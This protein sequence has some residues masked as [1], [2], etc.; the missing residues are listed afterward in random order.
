MKR[1]KSTFLLML[2]F[3][4]SSIFAQQSN[5]SNDRTSKETW[6][7]HETALKKYPD[8]RANDNGSNLQNSWY[9]DRA[10]K[11]WTAGLKGGVTAF[12]GDADKMVP[13]WIAGPFVKYSISQTF[14]LRAEYN[15]GVLNGE[16]KDQGPS[17]FKDQFNF[18]SNFQDWSIQAHFTLGNISFLRPLRKTQLYFFGG[19][20]QGAY[21]S[22]A[23]FTDMRLFTGDYYLTSYFGQGTPNPNFGLEVEETYEGRHAILPFGIGAKH[24]LS[25]SFD[26]GLE[27]RMTMVRSDEIDV[28]STAIWQNRNP[29]MY[30]VLA[31]SIGYKFGNKN[32]QHYDWLSPIESV[33]EK[34]EK[35]DSLMKDSDNDGVSDY[36]DKEP[37]T[38][39]D[40]EVYGSGKAVDSDGDGIPDCRD[41]EPFSPRGAEVDEDGVAIDSDG[42]GV[43]DI[44]DREPNSPPGALVDRNGV[45]II[46][47]CACEDVVFPSVYFSSNADGTI[48]P[49]YYSVL[50]QIAERM[51]A[52]P[53]KKLIISGFGDQ[54]SSKYNTT[55]NTRR[56]DAM[57]K[58]L[59]EKYGISRDRMIADYKGTMNKSTDTEHRG[60]RIDFR[61]E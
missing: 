13:G 56:I 34:V 32:S 14:G 23:T 54:R 30:S 19:I 9:Q 1:I 28:Y 61:F 18:T 17:M 16:R 60:R 46:Q 36:F 12:H 40:C 15:F 24:Y 29:D 50:Y 33:Y 39:E 11:K 4:V 37:E 7:R 22:T 58:H 51:K 3:G 25:K 44:Y 5:E 35:V 57:I 53:D 38:P 41:K 49:Q 27:Y 21:R 10:A 43:P 59:N 55:V 48:A 42:D 45:Q 31:L 6:K 52:C 2:A 47:C 26:I 8:G 20:G